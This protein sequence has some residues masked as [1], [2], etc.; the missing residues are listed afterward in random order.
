[1][2]SYQSGVKLGKAIN[3]AVSEHEKNKARYELKLDGESELPFGKVT[4]FREDEE[5][6]KY[7]QTVKRLK[8][9]YGEDYKQYLKGDRPDGWK[10]TW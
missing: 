5:R 1:M 10:Y 7:K 9:F 6:K 2:L 8:L 3:K 4:S